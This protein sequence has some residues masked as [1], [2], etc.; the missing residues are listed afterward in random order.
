M[1]TRTAA[2][3]L[4]V[5][6]PVIGMGGTASAQTNTTNTTGSVGCAAIV[7]AAANGMNTRIAA[8]DAT[9]NPPASVTQMTCL[10]NFFNGVGL[11]LVTN[12]LD[13]TTLLQAVEG[14]ICGLVQSTWSSLLGSAQC[15]LTITGFNMNFGGLGGGLSCPKLS[16][17][18]GGPPIA[19]VGIGTTTNASGSGL[20]ISGNGL[21]PSGY[22]P[23]TIPPGAL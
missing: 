18:G 17:G 22:T 10:T 21:A 9:I 16:F 3:A 12:L 13:P 14:Q 5:L 20:Y 11:N 6:M 23:S 15:G 19:S 2:M 4:A 8:D 7:Q 1:M